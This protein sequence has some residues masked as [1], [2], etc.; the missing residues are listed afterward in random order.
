M[1]WTLTELRKLR[2]ALIDAESYQ[3]SLADSY[4]DNDPSPCIQESIREHDQL[5]RQA[6]T[7]RRKV[8]E[9]IVRREFRCRDQTIQRAHRMV[10]P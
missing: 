10:E 9:E 1:R 5:T 8:V 7:L 4:D 6:V 3:S 2:N